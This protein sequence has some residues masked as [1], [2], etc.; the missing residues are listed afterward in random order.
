[1]S[2]LNW[3]NAR[4]NPGEFDNS[5]PTEAS[6]EFDIHRD[7][8]PGAP[9]SWPERINGQKFGPAFIKKAWQSGLVVIAEI[10]GFPHPV[11]VAE[12]RWEGQVL[13]VKCQEGFR[14]A[15]RIWTRPN[16]KGLTSTGLLIEEDH[17]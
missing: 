9:S 17:Q 4:H 8:R 15:D 7:T 13:E 14:V 5:A 11:A 10:E 1:V 3:A 2:R 16:A 6:Y 12:A